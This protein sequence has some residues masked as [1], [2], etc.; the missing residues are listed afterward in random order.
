MLLMQ[1]CLLGT[2]ARCSAVDS[3][4]EYHHCAV[5]G[6]QLDSSPSFGHL[7]LDGKRDPFHVQ[8]SRNANPPIPHYLIKLRIRGTEWPRIWLPLQPLQLFQEV[9]P[10]SPPTRVSLP[11][12]RSSRDF[13]PCFAPQGF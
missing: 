5:V 13:H 8:I 9:L 7:I 3:C 10:T 6:C 4:H 11:G 2:L 1:Q 12:T